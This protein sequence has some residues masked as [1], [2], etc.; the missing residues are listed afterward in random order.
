MEFCCPKD[1]PVSNKPKK[2]NLIIN[3]ENEIYE[4]LIYRMTLKKQT[5][6]N[7]LYIY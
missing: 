7:K 2:K 6:N 4:E 1:K 3:R 5:K